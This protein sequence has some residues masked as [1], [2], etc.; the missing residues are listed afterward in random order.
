[1]MAGAMSAC[2]EPLEAQWVNPTPGMD[3]GGGVPSR[4]LHLPTHPGRGA[5]C[6]QGPGGVRSHT[7]PSTARDIDLDT[8][9]DRDEPLYAPADGIAY[10][11]DADPASGFG[12]HVNIA[13]GDGTYANVS[14]LSRSVVRSGQ[15]LSAGQ[16]IGYE[17]CTGACTG[18][19]V[20]VGLHE[21]DASRPAQFGKSVPSAYYIAD[22]GAARGW[23]VLEHEDFICGIRS[24]G[25]AQDGLF[26]RSALKVPMHH[27][28]GTLVRTIGDPRVYRIDNGTLRWIVSEEVFHSYGYRFQDVVYVSE[29]EL[30]CYGRGAPIDAL[31][32]VDALYDPRGQLWLLVGSRT[33]ADRYRVK[34]LPFGASAVLSSWGLDFGLDGPPQVGDDHLSFALYPL[35][36]GTAQLRDGTLVRERARSDV[37]I[38]SDGIAMPIQDWQT[39]LRLGFGHR[40]VLMADD[41][42]LSTVQG[43][44]GSCGM[45]SWCLDSDVIAVCGGSFG[46]TKPPSPTPP[47]TTDD[48]QPTVPSVPVTTPPNPPS[49]RGEERGEDRY[50]ACDALACIRGSTLLLSDALWLEPHL[51]G[52]DA[53]FWG[54]GDCFAPYPNS[55]ERFVSVGGYYRLDFA[56]LGRACATQFTLIATVGTDDAPPDEHMANW[57]WYQYEPICRQGTLICDLVDEGNPWEQWWLSVAYYPATGLSGNG[58][59]FTSRAQLF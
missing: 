47:E 49:E 50:E 35:R 23:K 17:G 1:M 39:Y 18:D 55:Q 29:D 57:L 13:R 4:V 31:G 11:H 22:P 15:E 56:R 40:E 43:A 10:L 34:V 37:Y 7:L 19:H 21:G 58:N 33:S 41:G 3:M 5:M 24:T 38:V 48:P 53:H 27:P 44:V 8:A 32:K 12:I 51:Q 14:H 59:G 16:L 26:Y 52:V 28:N 42:V 25:D 20:H 2:F 9:N 45:P 46:T 6:T 54:Y 30:A 36:P